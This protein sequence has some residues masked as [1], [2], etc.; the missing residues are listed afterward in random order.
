MY[1]IIVYDIGTER[2]TRVC[3]Y[4][5]RYMNWVQNSVFEGDLSVSQSKRIQN[6]LEELID[7]GSDSIIIYTLQSKHALERQIIGQEK[8][9]TTN[10]L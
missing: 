2:V 3:H 4:L 7:K 5:R 1:T 6:T 9:R 10:I 8:A